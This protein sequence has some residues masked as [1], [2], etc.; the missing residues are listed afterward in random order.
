MK[1]LVCVKQV[2]EPGSVIGIDDSE[3]WIRAEKSTTYKMNRFDE[4]AVE[5][6]LLIRQAFPGT[7]VDVLS[8]GPDRAAM[9]VKRAIGMGAD[10]GVHMAIEDHGYLNPLTVASLIAGYARDRHYDLIFTGVMAEDDM[11]GM[12]GPMLAELL[13]LPCATFTVFEK[14]SPG[15]ETIYVE[16]EIKGG[17]RDTL[18]LKVPAVLTIQGG[19]NKPRYPSLSNM[20][21]AKHQKLETIAAR[22]D[23][24]PGP[25]E[26]LMRV[27]YPQKS[28]S[29][30]VLK[31]NQQEKAAQLL[32]ILREKTL[33]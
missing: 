25:R 14:I 17:Y 2:P 28:R 30:M 20:L 9:V 24:Q 1:I 5:E 16:R 12:V 11:Q 19:I 10:N 15:T 33:I 32:K 29:C 23:E 4:F 21:R 8:V 27:S 31:G 6:A 3:R 13:F 22:L 18:E 26:E 7:R